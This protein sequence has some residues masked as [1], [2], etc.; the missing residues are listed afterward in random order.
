MSSKGIRAVIF[1][2]DGTLVDSVDLHARSWKEIFAAYGKQVPFEEARRQIGK[3]ADQ[4]MPVFFS[5]EEIRRFGEEMEEARGRLFRSRYL[6][7][8]RPFPKTRE[9]FQRL[10]DDGVR[11]ALASSASREDLDE[12]TRLARIQ[13]LVDEQITADDVSQSKPHPEVFEVALEALGNP[14]PANVTVVGDTPYDVQ[15][16]RKAGLDT[17]GVLSGGFSE[18]DLR[19]AG[20]V[21][22]Y[23]DIE[24]LLAHYEES[25]LGARADEVFLGRLAQHSHSRL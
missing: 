12:Y 2:I 18:D 8:V 25:P 24:D 21:A 1:D 14:D 7:L 5:A 10:K 23:R 11:I 16:A 3:G 13:D 19:G 15:A 17:V 9:L 20:A 4:L 6:P 22:I